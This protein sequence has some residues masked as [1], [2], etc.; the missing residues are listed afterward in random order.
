MKRR[1]GVYNPKRQIVP[2]DDPS[3][4]R[5]RELAVRA[6]YDGNPQH[7]LRP[8]DYGL[9]PSHAPRPGKTLCDGAGPF[10]AELARALLR[11]G[12]ERGMIS[13]Q[14]RGDWPQNVW[15][16]DDGRAF[17]AE[18]TNSEQGS[19]RGYPLPADDDFGRVV[20]EAWRR[21]D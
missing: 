16:I 8:N 18:L 9:R 2:P 15:S 5:C 21:R 10:P 7:K 19:Y 1:Q 14:M 13:R 20:L 4:E 11:A 3:F 12:L 17:E 6:R